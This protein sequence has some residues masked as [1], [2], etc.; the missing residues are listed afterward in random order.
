MNFLKLDPALETAIYN[1]TYPVLI[2]I[3]LI[4]TDLSELTISHKNLQTLKIH[5]RYASPGVII[6]TGELLFSLPEDFTYLKV[7][8]ITLSFSCGSCGIYLTRF[9]FIPDEANLR[10][11]KEGGRNNLYSLRVEDNT[12][13]I[14]SSTNIRD[15][16]TEELIIDSVVCDK[17][18]PT[19][20][21]FHIMAL[22]AGIPASDI[23]CISINLPVPYAKLTRSPWEELKDL[24]RAMHATLYSGTD[25]SLILSGSR[26]Q[27]ETDDPEEI[28]SLNET[29]FYKLTEN[30]IGDKQYNDIRLK[31]NKPVRL[32]HQTLWTYSDEPAQYDKNLK[33]SYPFRLNGEKR[34][35]ETNSDYE[36]PYTAVD[37]EGNAHRVVYADELNPQ[38]EVTARMETQNDNI[39]I[40]KYDRTTYPDRAMINLSCNQDD[41]LSSLTIEGRPLVMKTNQACYR[42]DEEAIARDG[43]KILNQTG[44]YYL[45]AETNGIPH[46]EDWT[47]HTLETSMNEKHS[48]QGLSQYGLFFTQVGA[49]VNLIQKDKSPLTRITDILISY[50]TE[51]GYENTLTLEEL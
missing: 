45:D 30:L 17:E 50:N 34:E 49:K 6:T 18:H 2:R 11:I 29:L 40:V 25:K 44:K 35:I 39:S 23:D 13:H 12:A 32:P 43:L 9:T 15:W 47:D 48:Y 3:L 37:A 42:R 31:W 10:F 1:G 26:Y 7:K 28:P 38:E 51:E 20:S 8:E 27:A 24:T 46:Y 4:F 33:A 22:K 5:S 21:L 36:A 41:E 16:T 19:V 14:K